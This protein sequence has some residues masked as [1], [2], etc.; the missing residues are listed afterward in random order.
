MKRTHILGLVVLV[1]AA[2][3]IG[4][5]GAVT[6]LDSGNGGNAEQASTQYQEVENAPEDVA[7]TR[8]LAEAFYKEVRTYYPDARVF[9]TQQGHI[10]VEL[11]PNADSGEE[12][13]SE[14][15]RVAIQ[16]SETVNRTGHNASALSIV[17]GQVEMV[18]PA[19]PVERHAAG[20]LTD[21]AFAETIEV[22]SIDRNNEGGN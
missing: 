9:V 8:P 3:A 19:T 12:V 17:T 20:N 6:V 13:R 4:A 1:V 18:V 15:T 16:Y 5:V 21:K 11:S 14:L 2:G 22:R 10:M 7:E